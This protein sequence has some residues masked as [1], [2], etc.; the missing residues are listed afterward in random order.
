MFP[1]KI[2][3]QFLWV[4]C[5]V[6]L[7]SSFMIGKTYANP[8]FTSNPIDLAQA[9]SERQIDPV[10]RP[11]VAELET[12]TRVPLLLPSLVPQPGFPLYA[13]VNSAT[14]DAY[15]LTIGD[16]ENCSGG[17][18]CRFGSISGQKVTPSTPA[19]EKE[20][21]FMNDPGYRPSKRSEEP[22][23]WVVLTNGI[24]GYF[25]PYVCGANCDDSKVVWEQNGYR[26]LVGLKVGDKK[27]VVA[28]ATSAIA[29]SN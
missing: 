27:T 29:S 24:R 6:L 13:T 7:V 19:I 10:F 11:I 12:K 20:Y 8:F 4:V 1:T 3:K 28:M 21:S 15:E 16:R 22:M 26:Y 2:I 9:G 25:V 5:L 17:N 23:G 18:Y 14:V